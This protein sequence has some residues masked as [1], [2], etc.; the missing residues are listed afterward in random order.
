[1][2]K[3]EE[4]V[5]EDIKPS[6]GVTEPGAIAYAAA[7]AR[8]LVSGTIRKIEVVLNSGIYK[9]S[10]TCGVPNSDMTGC[11]AAAA[12]GAI[13]GKPEL[14]LEALRDAGDE[15]CQRAK[16][17]IRAGAVDVRLNEISSEVYICVK[18]HTDNGTSEAII[19]GGHTELV[20]LARDGEAL[21]D[22]RKA[23]ADSKAESPIIQYTLKQLYEYAKTVPLENIEFLREAYSMD[24]ALLGAGEKSGKTALS[25]AM[26][27][28]DRAECGERAAK[29][30]VCGA[31]EARVNGVPMP[32]M[33]ITGSG[34]HGILCMMPIFAAGKAEGLSEEET[35]RAVF[36]SCL[37]TMYI[38]EFSGKLSAACGCVLA[39]GTG[40]ALGLTVLYGGGYEDLCRALSNMA[41]SVTG[42][43]C[44]GGNPG[45]V[46]K[47]LTGVEMAF[48]ACRLALK[49]VCVAAEHGI[50]AAVPERT[51]RNMG[52]ISSPG[53][54]ETEKHIIE[55]LERMK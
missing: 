7:S 35:L 8:K 42:M 16:A 21:V 44:H 31:I 40:A 13:A 34:S 52:H 25:A 22:D 14:K 43:I 19:R 39:G 27:E 41:A 3:L 36:L 24:A 18:V 47:A 15:D 11:A 48:W 12:L 49:G 23:T 33:S 38:K 9:N 46:L 54:V 4:L 20:Y 30:A 2:K 45:C 6:L 17:L 26:T 29:Y 51:M 50:L 1:M 37:V 10:F 53:M 55:I 5:F 32:A 28:S